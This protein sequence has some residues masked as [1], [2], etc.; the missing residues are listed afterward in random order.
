MTKMSR[1]I[2]LITAA[3]AILT[4]SSSSSAATAAFAGRTPV[5]SPPRPCSRALLATTATAEMTATLSTLAKE[6]SALNSDHDDTPLVAQYKKKISTAPVGPAKTN[7]EAAME[8]LS[9]T[10]AALNHDNDAF[11][12]PNNSIKNKAAVAPAVPVSVAV[13]PAAPAFVAAPLPPP[14]QKQLQQPTTADYARLTTEWAAINKDTS[15][16]KAAAS[17]AVA[18]TPAAA[19][20]APVT[21]AAPPQKQQQQQMQ[22]PSLM[23]DYARLAT[24]WAAV[25]KDTD[26]MKPTPPIMASLPP[27]AAATLAA[28]LQQLPATPP[29]SAAVA[30]NAVDLHVLAKEWAARN[31]DTVETVAP[32]P[33]MAPSVSAP[34]VFAA[35]PAAFVPP[36]PPPPLSQTLA[37]NSMVAIMTSENAHSLVQA[38]KDKWEEMAAELAEINREAEQTFA[39]LNEMEQEMNRMI[40][41]M[42]AREVDQQQRYATLEESSRLREEEL[43]QRINLLTSEYEMFKRDALSAHQATAQQAAERQ[44]KLQGQI[45]QLQHDLQSKVQALQQESKKTQLYLSKHQQTEMELHKTRLEAQQERLSMHQEQVESTQGRIQMLRAVNANLRH[46]SSGSREIMRRMRIKLQCLD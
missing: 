33:R 17:V 5:S 22:Q 6:W 28:P 19:A 29:P 10:W 20:A 34:P 32:T 13:A 7:S 44:T 23:S 35:A 30:N 18:F 24:E 14:P 36:P 12:Y 9:K 37:S 3:V 27:P 25:N 42:Q 21:V 31:R 41:K 38:A 1:R 4:V 2:I 46:M 43:L 15:T 11:R 8:E 40:I 16:N 26:K 45:S 39:A